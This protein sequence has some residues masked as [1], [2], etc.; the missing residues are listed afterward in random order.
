MAKE[1]TCWNCG[2][3]IA[4][5]PMPISRHS[6]CRHCF[7][8]IHCCRACVH[9][10]ERV[11]GSCA[12][13]LADPPVIKESANFCD[14]FK[15]ASTNASAVDGTK[16]D[17]ARSALGSLFGDE[18]EE[19]FIYLGSGLVPD[20]EPEVPLII[21]PPYMSD[22]R[23]MRMLYT[24]FAKDIE[25]PDSELDDWIEKSLEARRQLKAKEAEE[26]SQNP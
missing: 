10:N 9:F 15:L 6:N 8:V 26:D 23:K 14:F 24:T 17:R 18:P 4:D 19:P 20:Q 11:S 5:I 22:G 7:E 13:D 12:H 1:P 25:I 3:S 16:N 21:S 2:Q